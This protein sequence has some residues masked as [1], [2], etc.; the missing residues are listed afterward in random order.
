VGRDNDQ[1]WIEI[2]QT[3]AGRVEAGGDSDGLRKLGFPKTDGVVE[4]GREE[5]HAGEANAHTCISHGPAFVV[6]SLREFLDDYFHGR[7]PVARVP[8]SLGH[9][10]PFTREVLDAVSKVP[11]G[12]KV[13]YAELA[14]R[15]GRP[16]GARAVGQALGRNPVPIVVPCHRVLASSGRLGGYGGGSVWKQRLLRIEGLEVVV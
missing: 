12:S 6:A 5:T 4:P 1:D 2:I 9:L 14:R 3:P 8:L 10:T 7:V 15:V 16:R 11:W 13:S